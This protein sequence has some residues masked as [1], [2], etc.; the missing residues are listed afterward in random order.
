MTMHRLTGPCAHG[1]WGAILALAISSAASLFAANLCQAAAPVLLRTSGYESP[2]QAEAGDLLLLAGT[3][4]GPG[5]RV[6]YRATDTHDTPA[7]HPAGVPAHPTA[8][9]GTA[10]IVKRS[11]YGLTVH[12]PATLESHAQYRLWAVSATG[13]WSAPVSINDPRPLWVSPAFFYSS[14]AVAGL[15]R[16]LR[17]VG[18]NLQ[19]APRRT[20]E[21]RLQ[22]PT[23]YTLEAHLDPEHAAAQPFV[24]EAPVPAQMM[25]GRYSIAVSRD[26]QAWVNVPDQRLEVRPDPP[27]LPRFE[28]SE[29][30]FGSC[31]PDDAVDDTACFAKALQAAKDAGGGTVVFPA[32]KWDLSTAHLAADLQRDGLILGHNVHVQGAGKGTTSIIRHDTQHAPL[33]GALLTLVG[34]NS[35]TGL[36]FTDA[37]PYTSIQ[38]SRPVIQLGKRPSGSDDQT[39]A[40][41]DV[42]ISEN[43]FLRV[44]RAMVD[45]S[46]PMQRLLITHNTFGGYDNA[47]LLTGA[48]ASLAHPYRID[49]SIVRQNRFVPGSFLD[50]S[51]H[52]GAIATQLGASH[53]VDFSENVADGSATEG[54]QN[55][56]DPRG[57]R[58]AFFWNIT[59]NNEELLIA[60]NQVSCSGDKAGDG[61]AF[62]FDGHGTTFGFDVAQTVDAS[63]S[64]WVSVHGDLLHVQNGQPVP[65]GYYNGHWLTIIQG[66]GLGQ[67]RRVVHYSEDRATGRVTF[68]VEP[69]WDV[70]PAQGISQLALGRQYWQ[71]YVVANQVSQAKPPCQKS[72]FNGPR[73]G[74]IGFWTPVADSVIQ[75]NRQ[76][77]SDGIEYLQGYAAKT[78]SCRDCMGSASHATALEIRANLID[79][80]YDWDSDCSWS[81]VRGYYWATPTPEAPPPIVGFG[82]V[83]AHNSIIH[84]DGQ[85][86][87]AIDI[88]SAGPVGLVGPP[89]GNW[90]MVQNVLIFGN[91]IRDI[92]GALP[93]PACHDS[94]RQRVGIHLEGQQIIRDAVLEGNRCEGVDHFLDDAGA[95]TA[96]LCSPGA[97]QTCECPKR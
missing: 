11:P 71:V 35:V 27:S 56:A 73:G 81:G 69:Q 29:P 38:E 55:P 79:G 94:Q 51:I 39:E 96:A 82:T 87:G 92:A 41:S 48:G 62:S 23:T 66:P 1:R 3:G 78:A 91:L 68:R 36:A 24:I 88:A 26:R 58:A 33:P 9:E 13:E 53:R 25:P 65:D 85:R 70:I 21:I 4:F 90:T 5:D 61:E 44:G 89:P 18:R 93:R 97:G 74:V 12:L 31:R 10:P 64:D 80:E 75:S 7:S 6:V 50:V 46:R 22:G 59:N 52:Q 17:V 28:V 16:H 30:R 86:G 2:V 76:F 57:W 67:T 95:D 60:E 8:K 42:V 54:L 32:G 14:A 40:V 72:N 19:P 83:I 37:Q 20:V 49:D 34:E 15:N 43:T 77:D 84:A 63:G 45:S 47:L